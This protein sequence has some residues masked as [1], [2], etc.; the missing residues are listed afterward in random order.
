MMVAPGS[1]VNLATPS[2]GDGGTTW[3][4][5][6]TGPSVVRTAVFGSPWLNVNPD[7]TYG[8]G[9][10]FVSDLSNSPGPSV[11]APAFSPAALRRRAPSAR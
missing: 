11:R 3:S 4:V 6:F 9:G 1:L 7:P 2:T 5:E 10:V 8:V